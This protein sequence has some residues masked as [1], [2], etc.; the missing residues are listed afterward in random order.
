M[1]RH[2]SFAI[3]STRLKAASQLSAPHLFEDLAAA[4]NRLLRLAAGNFSPDKYRER[5]PKEAEGTDSG[6]TPWQLFERWVVERKQRMEQRR[7]GGTYSQCCE[8]ISATAVLLPLHP[9]KLMA[10]SRV[11][12][13]RSSASPLPAEADSRGS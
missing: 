1:K 9:K 6:V 5:F 13:R 4:L 10:G 11:F 7:V 3:G 8:T 2:S 12:G